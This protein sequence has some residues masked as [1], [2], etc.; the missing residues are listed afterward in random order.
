MVVSPSSTVSPEEAVAPVDAVLHVGPQR[1]LEASGLLEAE[2]PRV[3]GE[4]D[5]PVEHQPADLVGE[6]VGVGRA[7]L[8]AVGR[9]EEDQLRLTERRPQHVHVAGRLD[10]GDVADEVVGVV[11]AALVE[12]LEGLLELL[13][14]LW[15]VRVGVG[16]DEVV[17]GGVGD[18]V[19]RIG[20]AGAAR[21]EADDVEGVEELLAERERRVLGVRRAGRAGPAGVDDQ[22]ADPARRIGGRDLEQRQPDGLAGRL[23]VVDGHRQRRALEVAAARL[24]RQLL[25]VERREV[26][27]GRLGGAVI[28]RRSGREGRGRVAV[29]LP[30]LVAVLRQA[31]GDREDH[32]RQ[33]RD[34][35]EAGDQ[36]RRPHP[37]ARSGALRATIIDSR[38]RAT[39]TLNSSICS[40]AAKIAA[41][42]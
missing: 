41:I 14:L 20:A 16:R 26:R 36:S 13:P 40:R 2:L 5:G 11:D 10:R 30:G 9:A 42:R 21:V 15:R 38:A 27:S 1:H 17:E 34:H 12:G 35:D 31:L 23:L 24:P 18:A 8:G 7:E 32:D 29:G 19:D 33:Q 4:V 6:Q 39:G 22:R 3:D 28:G 37:R 25:G